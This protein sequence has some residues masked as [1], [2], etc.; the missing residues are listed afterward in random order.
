MQ[1]ATQSFS[2]G[3]TEELFHWFRKNKFSWK[4]IITN[5]SLSSLFNLI[6]QHSKN[7]SLGKEK[8]LIFKILSWSH[9]QWINANI[10]FH[11]SACYNKTFLKECE[12]NIYKQLPDAEPPKN[13]LLHSDFHTNAQQNDIRY[14]Y[15][16]YLLWSNNKRLLE[17]LTT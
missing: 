13:I 11:F 1:N 17:P 2:S 6:P 16:M 14:V 4:C 7:L 10:N 9:H 8:F 12:S 3:L 15:Q 5:I